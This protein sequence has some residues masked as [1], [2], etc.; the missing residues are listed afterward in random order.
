MLARWDEPFI[1][2]MQSEQVFTNLTCNQ[3]CLY[4]TS[5]R[6]AEQRGFVSPSAVRQRIQTA[7]A[8]GAK[9][10]VLTGGEPTMRRDLAELITEAR[11]LGARSIIVETNATL[12]DAK[13][14]QALK[15]AGLT[16]ARV[17]LSG[18]GD[19]LDAI[20][21]D[22]GGFV[23]TLGGL[24][25]LVGAGIPVEVVFNVV[26]PTLAAASEL[27]LRLRERFG[28]D[29]PAGSGL[30]IRLPIEAPMPSLLVPYE[31]AVDAILAL[32]AAC[33]EVGLPRRIS[34]E[35]GPPP[36]VFPQPAVVAHLYS[37]SPG[38]S[39]R[40]GFEHLGACAEC[41]LSRACP[42]VPGSYLARFSAP[43]IRPI[44]DDRLRRRLFVASSVEEQIRREF[45]EPQHRTLDGGGELHEDLIRINF[46]CNQACKFCFVSTHLPAAG[47]EAVRRAIVAAAAA[48]RAITLTGGEPTLNPHL[49]EYVRLARSRSTLPVSMQTNAVRL[50]DGVL[51]RALEEAGLSHVL[52][53]LHGS[54]AD[55]SDCI[56][57]VPGTF[58]M[59]VAGIDQLRATTLHVNLNI[60]VC[61]FNLHD[62]ASYVR[63]IGSRWP[64]IQ[65]VFSFVSL[66]GDMVPRDPALVPRYSEAVAPLRE[67]LVEAR[68]RGLRLGSIHHMCAM[69]LCLALEAGDSASSVPDL[70]TSQHRGGFVKP[71]VCSGCA[72]SGKCFGLRASYLDLY[73]ASELRPVR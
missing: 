33:R 14:A 57:G 45:V 48:G 54:N 28:G 63:F 17:N 4:C 68:K 6:S 65:T 43:A 24:R 19:E 34:P 7:L 58:A 5:R 2:A 61:R 36:C 38:A 51:V 18:W 41:K 37:L 11:E 32:D 46:H 29:L 64:G 69:P 49:L 47:D 70:P 35:S 23:R 72:L 15:E 21:R 30:R 66:A 16:L 1:R 12:L 10:L 25:A 71:E 31:R 53:A 20:T 27:P 73:D 67:A 56:T 50:V 13:R 8:T 62:L 55:V 44:T 22:E 9:E 3:N 52:V 26:K 40:Q 39:A 60:V 42:G 59:T